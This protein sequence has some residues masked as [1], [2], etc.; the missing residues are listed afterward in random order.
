MGRR[1]SQDAAG[2]ATGGR[3][4]RAAMQRALAMIEEAYYEASEPA[5]HPTW[6]KRLLRRPYR[7]L[8]H[9]AYFAALDR[10]GRERGWL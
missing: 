9:A 7:Q 6:W 1:G 2:V 4:Y 3:R 10:L 8:D 5:P